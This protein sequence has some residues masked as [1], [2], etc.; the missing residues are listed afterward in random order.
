MGKQWVLTGLSSIVACCLLLGCGTPQPASNA[1]SSSQAPAQDS[2]RPVA[3]EAQPDL[4]SAYLSLA[5]A[6]GK[7]V[8]LDPAASSVRVYVFRAGTAAALGHN[9]VLTV[10]EFTGFF[11]APSSGTRGARFDIVFRLDRLEIDRP[12]IRATLGRAY[13]STVVP[14]MVAATRANMLGR[15]NLEADRFPLVHVRSLGTSGEAPKIAAR[16]QIELHGQQRELWVPLDVQGLPERLVVTG[17]LVL[18]QSD[19]GIK[20]FS[21]LGGLLAVEDELVVEFRLVGA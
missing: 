7:L 5:R 18:R 4:E 9:H 14:E 12:D 8:R 2:S 21:V 20:P 15:D 1:A 13:A 19:F 16:I 17:T 11:H 10:P 6:G 3:S